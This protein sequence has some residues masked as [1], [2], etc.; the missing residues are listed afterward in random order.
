MRLTPHNSGVNVK[1]IKEFYKN[2]IQTFDN[3]I[4][5]GY[6]RLVQVWIVGLCPTSIIEK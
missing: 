3:L 4:K 6:N 5:L 1:I 2:S